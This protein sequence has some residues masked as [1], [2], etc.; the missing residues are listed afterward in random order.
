MDIK[1]VVAQNISKLM[2]ESRSLD[3]IKKVAARSGIGAETVRRARNGEGNITVDNLAAVAKAFGV[4]ITYMVSVSPIEPSATV[5]PIKIEQ[6][7]ARRRRVDA[8]HALIEEISEIG[9]AVVLDK[10]REVSKE[11]PAKLKQTQ[12]S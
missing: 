5:L 7:T 4:D 1:S 9:L 2:A 11:Y 12:S 8:I 6:K 10:C 3:T